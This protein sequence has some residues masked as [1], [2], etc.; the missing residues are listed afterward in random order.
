MAKYLNDTFQTVDVTMNDSIPQYGFDG[1]KEVF[2]MFDELEP[3]EALGGH[4]LKDT[5]MLEFGIDNLHFL[6]L[7]VKSNVLLYEGS[8]LSRLTCTLMLLNACASH[9]C[10]NGFVDEPLSL[11]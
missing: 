2:N 8:H 5:T 1:R 10:T 3:N 4:H 7:D 6:Q 9:R 11:L